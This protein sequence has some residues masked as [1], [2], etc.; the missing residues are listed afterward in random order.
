MFS[1]HLKAIAQALFVTFLW[2]TSW[3]FIKIGLEDIPPLTFAGLRYSLA[4]V[5]LLLVNLRVNNTPNGHDMTLRQLSRRDWGLL[6]LLGLIFYTA[7][8]GTQFLA[9]DHLPAITLSLLLNFTSLVV[10]FMGIL[11]ISEHL[12]RR[13]WLGIG[14]FL[15]GVLIYFNPL[16]DSP[17]LGLVIG[18]T[19]MLAN[20]AATVL[21]RYIN[22]EARISAL[23]VTLV[24]MGVGSIVLLVI[25]IVTQGLPTLSLQ[26]WLIILWLAVVN[27]A[28]AFTLWNYTQ[29]TLSAV[30][31]SI[32]NNTMLLQIAVLAWLFLDE[33][34]SVQGGIGLIIAAIGI[35]MVQL[36]YNGQTI[37][38]TSE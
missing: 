1:P 22:R 9:L 23:L 15:A 14:V 13:Q 29:R 28:F 20:S 16:P 19:S 30:E 2:S 21:G 27:T 8:Q 5:V 33:G 34:I 36:R 6:I 11:F 37:A 3:V 4:F 10:A 25:G 38:P 17:L 31:T 26:S 18:I 24:S 12:T 7:T 32:I 35:L